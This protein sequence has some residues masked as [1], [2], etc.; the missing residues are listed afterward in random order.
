MIISL[1]YGLIKGNNVTI[2]Y[3]VWNP[4]TCNCEIRYYY[5]DTIPQESRTLAVDI[6]K[7]SCLF[8]QNLMPN[9]PVT[10][11]C[12]IDENTR[13]SNTLQ[14]ALENLTNK[15]GDVFTNENGGSYIVLKNSIEFRFRF[16]GISPN[17][18]L[19]VSFVG[20]NLST[21]EIG[22]IQTKLNNKFGNDS[23]I[24]EAA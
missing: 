22:N 20:A 23:V 16:E 13:K 14:L 4:D 3:N 21:N 11:A 6:V 5:D 7:K 15:L 8:H 17:R 12:V 2:K 10:Y 9:A 18:I 24:I 19:Y 1:L